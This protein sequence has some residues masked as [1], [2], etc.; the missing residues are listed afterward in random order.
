MSSAQPFAR[1]D[2][3]S[4]P[5]RRARSV[6][7]RIASKILRPAGFDIELRHFYSPVPQ[8]EYVADEFWT[9]ASEL[10][11]TSGFDT[12]A[13]LDWLQAHLTEGIAQFRP[14]RQRMG[15]SWNY[16]LDNG[17]YQGVDADLL[18]AIIRCLRPRLVLELGAGFS[19]LC[20]ALA[21]EHNRKDG[22]ATELVT[23]DP[24]AVAPAPGAVQGLSE[25]RPVRAE[26]LPVSEYGR[27]SAGDILFI[28]SSHTVKVGGD[29]THLFLEVLPRLQPGVL[30][31]VH[32]V[33][34]PWHYPRE[35]LAHN[36]WYWA[37]QYLLQ[38]YLIGNP[39]VEVLFAAYAAHRR[40]PR[41]LGSLVP[42]YRPAAAPLSLWLRTA[43][44]PS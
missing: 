25:L 29:V 17:L 15:S 40:D 18:Y 16:H 14:P 5:R 19:T 22:H 1:R 30:V 37:E 2:Y 9:T 21:V 43:D 28:D 36:R 7:V 24:Y 34:L 42:N 10:P 26:D 38:A 20:S 23:C 13:H 6:A 12:D 31:H 41:R 44:A 35:W 4:D 27:L 11:G 33:F 3:Y 39:N 32:D 8:L